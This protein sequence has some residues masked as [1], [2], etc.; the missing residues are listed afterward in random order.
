MFSVVT[1]ASQHGSI[2]YERFS[3]KNRD[4]NV[5]SMFPRHEDWQFPD[6]C[7]LTKILSVHLQMNKQKTNSS[8][9]PAHMVLSLPISK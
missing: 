9:G 8:R 7:Q 1:I 2:D 5:E 3:K 6:Q 4:V